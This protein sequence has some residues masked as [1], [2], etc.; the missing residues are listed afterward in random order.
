MVYRVQ[1][2]AKQGL[3]PMDTE[4]TTVGCR[5]TN[6]G[7]CGK[8]SQPGVCAFARKDGVCISPPI[9]WPRRYRAMLVRQ[10][11]RL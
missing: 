3:H 4:K 11:R 6:P 1:R 5:H 2:P 9:S 10:R 7:I 8:N